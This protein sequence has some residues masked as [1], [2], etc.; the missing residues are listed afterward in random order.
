[1]QTD[2]KQFKHKI[3]EEAIFLD[4]NRSEHLL[5]LARNPELII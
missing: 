1:M 4:M 3:V 2:A 5:I